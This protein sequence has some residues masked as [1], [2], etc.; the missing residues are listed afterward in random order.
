MAVWAGVVVGEGQTGW[1]PHQQTQCKATPST[2]WEQASRERGWPVAMAPERWIEPRDPQG[3]M[4]GSP[5]QDNRGPAVVEGGRENQTT[6][7][8]K[9]SKKWYLYK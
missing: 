6:A 9:I 5:W 4:R 3:E 8:L 1:R 7:T 2:V